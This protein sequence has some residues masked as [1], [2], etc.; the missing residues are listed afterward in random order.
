MA[1]PI[2]RASGPTAEA[3]KPPEVRG[4]RTM[5][6]DID[7]EVVQRLTERYGTA[8]PPERLRKLQDLPTVFEKRPEFDQSFKNA[9]GELPKN[10]KVLGFVRENSQESPHVA[11]DQEAEMIASVRRHEG[12]HQLADPTAKEALGKGLYE[13]MTE[14]MARDTVG[15]LSESARADDGGRAYE[16]E[17]AL[18]QSLAE[19]AGRDV[20]ENAYL[21]GDVETLRAKVDEA[22]GNGSLESFGAEVRNWDDLPK[23]E[24]REREA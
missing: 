11:L 22:L 2:E 21:K 7:G 1:H 9:G 18:A 16:Q 10:G 6:S 23:D 20:V 5:F 12:V 19:V 4:I 13:G 8:V 17:T 3:V 15:P 14:Y 24:S